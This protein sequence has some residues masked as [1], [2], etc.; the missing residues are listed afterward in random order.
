[1]PATLSP[2]STWLSVICARAIASS[3]RVAVGRSVV[4]FAW[5]GYN[6]LSFSPLCS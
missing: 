6:P 4:R 5:P 1:M 2:L 3:T